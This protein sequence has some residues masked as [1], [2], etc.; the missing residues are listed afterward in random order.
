MCGWG[1]VWVWM[2]CGGMQIFKADT[3]IGLSYKIT[4]VRLTYG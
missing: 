3:T 4:C 2:G 1:G